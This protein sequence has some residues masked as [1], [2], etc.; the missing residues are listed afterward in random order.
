M[1]ELPD[2]TVYVE[3]L[4]PRVVGRVVSRVSVRS[5][6]LVRTFE[7]AIDEVPGRVVTGVERLGKRI[8]LSLGPREGAAEQQGIFLAIHLMIAGRLLWKAPGV[9]PTGR[10][11][12]AA[13]EFAE[14]TEGAG[15]AAAVDRPPPGTLILTEASTK[16]RA[17]VHVLGSRAALA[18]LAPVGL[19]VFA[20]SGPDFADRLRSENRTLKRALTSPRLFDGIGNAYSDEMLWEARLSPIKLTSAMTG[21]EI[22]RLHAAARATLSHWTDVLRREFGLDAGVGGV[23]GAGRFPGSREITAFHP[24]FAVHGKFGKPC[25]RCGHVVARIVRAENEVNY[26]PTCQT[27]GKVFAD[28]LLSRL[29]K[30]DWPST[31]EEWEAA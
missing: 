30:D 4:R 24:G 29:L 23:G 20:C 8:V 31:V 14:G 3:A 9:K 1:P 16:K 22:E 2:V 5:P 13:I 26:C 17:A 6:F 19:D 12:L 7:P 15:A 28:R 21:E 18:E 10:I 27:G 11:D 25:P